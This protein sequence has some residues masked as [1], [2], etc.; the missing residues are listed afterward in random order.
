MDGRWKNNPQLLLGRDEIVHTWEHLGEGSI[1]KYW[2]YIQAFRDFQ[3]VLKSEKKI[4]CHCILMRGKLS[5]SRD[6]HK[7]PSGWFQT[8]KSIKNTPQGT[9]K[10]LFRDR[11]LYRNSEETVPHIGTV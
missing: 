1:K 6:P 8:Y 3:P 4:F 5:I 7:G 11:Q 9:E 2:L 10:V